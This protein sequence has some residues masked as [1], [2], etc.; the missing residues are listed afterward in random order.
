MLKNLKRPSEISLMWVINTMWKSYE[1]LK[2][3]AQG[4]FP[5]NYKPV[6]MSC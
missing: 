6:G 2:N 4:T 5:G 3:K 1:M